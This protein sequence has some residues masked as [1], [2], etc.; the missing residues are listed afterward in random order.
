MAGRSLEN[1]DR[2]YGGI[3]R[4]SD[5]KSAAPQRHH[6]PGPK[7]GP[8]PT[9]KPQDTKRT[10]LRILSYVTIYWKRIV[11]ALLCMLL[12]TGASLAGSY[13]LRPIVNV[14]ADA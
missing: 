4:H 10:L 14:I 9:G 6:G 1:L 2:R 5:G 13:L 12:S 7:H 3:D 11:G 8:G